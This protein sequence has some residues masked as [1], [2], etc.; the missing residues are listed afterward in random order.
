MTVPDVTAPERAPTRRC[1][2]PAN[3]PTRGRRRPV[4]ACDA[5]P[6][7]TRAGDQPGAAK[8]TRAKA[9]KRF[10]ARIR[11]RLDQRH[12]V[13]KRP[14]RR[15][16]MLAREAQ[17][18]VAHP[19]PSLRIGRN[20]PHRSDGRAGVCRPAPPPRRHGIVGACAKLK[21]CGPT[22]TGTPTA[23]ASI[24]FWPP[25]GK[26]AAADERDIARR[27]IHRHLAHR[28]AEHDR[29]VPGAVGANSSRPSSAAATPRAA[30]LDQARDVVEAL[31]M[32]RHHDHERVGERRPSLTAAR[33]GAVASSP[34][35][36][37]AKSS[38]GRARSGCRN[39][40]P[41]STSVGSA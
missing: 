27:V 34:S 1:V 20:L 19:R 25:S 40:R 13:L 29:R 36:V 37:V 39:A 31:R 16:A 17:R 7:R 28:V 26:Q 35:R 15:A 18:G 32:A 8:S 5:A 41:R 12:D 10:L 30:R 33:R 21:V 22:T 9:A 2:P 24:R 11:R 3:P 4:D 6:R 38:T 14:R 23:H